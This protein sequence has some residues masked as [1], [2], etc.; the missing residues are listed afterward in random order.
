MESRI[1]TALGCL[2]PTRAQEPMGGRLATGTPLWGVKWTVHIQTAEPTLRRGPT[3]HYKYDV[4]DGALKT[5]KT[6]TSAE[7]WKR[8]GLSLPCYMYF[9]ILIPFK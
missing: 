4:Q 9:T 6:Q 1:H 7:F 8:T 5:P 3:E 2:G